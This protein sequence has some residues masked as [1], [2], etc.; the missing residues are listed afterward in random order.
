[1]KFLKIT[2]LITS[3]FVWLI[4]CQSTYNVSEKY[5]EKKTDYFI[6]DG[7]QSLYV[8]DENPKSD[9]VQSYPLILNSTNASAQENIKINLAGRILVD[10]GVFSSK[11]KA[12]ADGA[13]MPDQRLGAK[14]YYGDYYGKIDIG[15]AN[16]RINLKDVFIQRKLSP[17]STFKVGFF[18]PTFGLQSTTSSSQKVAVEEL[19]SNEIFSTNR[20]IGISYGYSKK[21]LFGVATAFVENQSMY[22][23][24]D[25]T[26]KQAYGLM[27]RFVYRSL[28]NNNVIFHIGLSGAYE[29]PRWNSKPELSH[30]SFVSNINF[31]SRIARVSAVRAEVAN[32]ENMVKF[33]PEILFASGS[34]AVESQY[35]QANIS[36]DKGYTNYSAHG[37]Q[38]TVRGLLTGE[39]YKYSTS[40]SGLAIPKPGSIECVLS[41]SYVDMSH[42]KANILGGEMNDIG[43]SLSYYINKYM[44]WRF[45]Y[46]HTEAKNRAGVDSQKFNAFQTRLQII[47]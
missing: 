15:F 24:S 25:K 43:L 8:E 39:N 20:S 21:S 1:M 45:R 36:R 16:G 22:E 19:A 31:P 47:F 12:F 30:S 35:T 34:F 38:A 32:A 9:A 10:A 11:N 28:E 4:S 3:V 23:S 14:A 40:N 7:K 17:S 33:A 2:G 46:S 41:Y 42:K 44:M 6:D 37:A 13:A 26:D 29:E 27:G 18:I 5:S